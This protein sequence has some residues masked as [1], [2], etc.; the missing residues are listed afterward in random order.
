M[1]NLIAVIAV[2]IFAFVAGL[3]T[4]WEILPIN[5]CPTWL[6][7]LYRFFTERF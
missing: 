4:A 6:D 7:N 3:F 2:L 5:A 1:F